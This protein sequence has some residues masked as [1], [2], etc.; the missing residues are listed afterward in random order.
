MGA[1]RSRRWCFDGG[2]HWPTGFAEF[3][4]HLVDWATEVDLFVVA[5]ARPELFERHP[6]WG[7][8]QRNSVTVSLPPLTDED[9][10]RLVAALLGQSVLTAETQALLLE[11][12]GG[13][14]LYAEEFVRLL[15]DRRLLVQGGIRV[16]L[17]EELP[18]PHT[19]QALIAA[20]LDA[21]PPERKALLQDAAVVGK[22]FWSGA[23]VAMG[24]RRPRSAAPARPQRRADPRRAASSVSTKRNT[25]GKHCRDVAYAQIP[26]GRV[27]RHQA[28]AEWLQQLAGDRVGDRA[29]MIAHHYT[30]ALALTRAARAPRDEV[31]RL[32][33]PAGRFLALAGDR[34][35]NLDPGR[36]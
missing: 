21:L 10:A 30:Q 7:G 13:N 35:V 23:L 32:E 3:L 22:V 5:T 14:P 4:E 24:G 34:A 17:R 28:A 29:E 33:E 19:L 15:T 25:S 36:A 27:R 11:R 6:G 16:P 12:A 18:L 26:A 2:L 20:R 1:R 31:V 9:T 8:G